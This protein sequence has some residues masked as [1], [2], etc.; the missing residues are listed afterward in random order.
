MKKYV[1]I[2]LLAPIL[3]YSQGINLDLN[4]VLLIN[5]DDGPFTVPPGKVWKIESALINCSENCN[6]SVEINQSLTYFHLDRTVS[7]SY[8]LSPATSTVITKL[9]MW[10]PEGTIIGDGNNIKHLSIL[11]FNTE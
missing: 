2:I 7:I 5:L 1:F 10:I 11:E 6:S 8:N 4:Q 9:P 3:I